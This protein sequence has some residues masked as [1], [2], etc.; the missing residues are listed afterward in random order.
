MILNLKRFN[1]FIEY[2]H[3]KMDTLSHILSH[4]TKNCFMA[5]FNFTDAYLTV[6]ISGHHVKFLKF[7][8]RGQTFMYV[9]LPFGISSAPR[10]FTN[11]LKP[12][13]SFLRRQGIIVLTYIDD[14]FTVMLTFEACYW[15]ICYILQTFFYFGFLIH[16]KKLAPVPSRQIHSLAFHV[17]SVTMNITLP[18]DKIQKH[19]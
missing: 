14:G 3:F 15:N 8:W 13:L 7:W 18:S 12:I 16:K 1:R 11:L 17:N 9:V 5:V 19:S 10:K 2:Q 4:I 6:S